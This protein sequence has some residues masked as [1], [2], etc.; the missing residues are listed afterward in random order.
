[1]N[2]AFPPLIFTFNKA[3]I[4]LLLLVAQRATSQT[5]TLEPFSSGFNWLV[6]IANAPGD[7]HLFAFQ[8]DGLI[9]IVNANGTPGGTFLD[10]G[11]KLINQDEYGL[12]GLV[13]HPGYAL[14]GFFYVYYNQVG[15]GRCIIARYNRSAANP[16]LA[17]PNSELILLSFDHP[18]SHHVGGCMKFGWDGKLYIATGDGA[19]LTAPSTAAQNLQSYLGKVLRIDVN[20]GN[21]YSVPTNN[22]FVNN[23]NAKPEIWAYGLRNPWR[24]S[25]DR[26]LGDLWIADVGQDQREEI[27][28]QP[29]NN[30]G[31]Q[32]YGWPCMEG[33]LQFNPTNCN[34][35]TTYTAPYYEYNHAT[36][37]G[38]SI[39]GGVVYRGTEY[40]DLFGKYIYSDFCSGRI[41]ALNN[42]GATPVIVEGA[43]VAD[44][45]ITM[46]EEN[47]KGELF[48]V[49]FFSN[50]IYRVRSQNCTPVAI[51]NGGAVQ[52]IPVGGSLDL[53]AYS[54]G[55]NYNYQWKLNGTNLPNQTGP[56][57]TVTQPGSYTLMVTK[58]GTNCTNTSAAVT[59]NGGGGTGGGNG[60]DLSL[61]LQQLTASPAQWSN[62]PVKLT[63]SNAGSQAATG[64]KVKFAK[65]TGVVYVGGNEFT[66]SQ[67]TFNP[68]GDEV[69]TVGSIP[70]NGSA[71]LTVNYFLLN[72]TAPV[73]Y[74]QVT[75]ANET[76]SDSQPNNGTPPTPVQDDE[77]STAGGS[78]G[79]NCQLSPTITPGFCLG[80]NTPD[81]SDDSYNITI[82]ATATGTTSTG[83]EVSTVFPNGFLWGT[84]GTYGVPQEVLAIPVSWG[85]RTYT[86]TDAG[87]PSC[88]ATVNVTPPPC[89]PQNVPNLNLTN[90]TTNI[91]AQPMPQ[92]AN[93][94]F[95][96][97]LFNGTSTPVSSAFTVKLY[98]SV[99]A[100]FDAGDLVIGT[101]SYP[102]FAANTL[103]QNQP[104]TATVPTNQPV[105]TYTLFVRADA[106]NVIT[107]LNEADNQDRILNG[108]AVVA[109]ST[110]GG[111]IDLSLTAQQLTASPAQWS[112]YPVKLTLSNTGPQ[113]ATGVK[114]KF[115]K[116]TGVVYVGGNEFTASQGT[117]NPNGDEVWTVG[118]IPANGSATLTVNYFLLN[119]TAPIAYAQ[120]TA[121]NET[122]A[123]SQPNNGTPPTPVQDDE[124]STAG[125]TP[126]PMPDLTLSN[127]SIP[128]TFILT[129][130]TAISYNVNNIGNAPSSS[131]QAFITRFYLSID[132]TLSANDLAVGEGI[133]GPVAAGGN[134]TGAGA[135]VTI[136]AS[137]AVGSYFLIGKTDADNTVAESNENNNLSNAVAVQV[138]SNNTLSV[139]LTASNLTAP[140]TGARGAAQ[141]AYS[142]KVNNIGTS[143]VS[144]PGGAGCQLFLSTDNVQG[145]AD[146][147]SLGI[148]GVSVGSTIQP[149]G[150]QLVAGTFTIQA[151]VQPGNYF[152]YAKADVF[153]EV[154]ENN[155]NNNNTQMA[156]LSVTNS[157]ITGTDLSPTSFSGGITVNGN[158]RYF[159]YT[160]VAQNTGTAI[161]GTSTVTVGF[162]LSTDNLLSSNDYLILST[163]LGNNGSGLFLSS[164][165][166]ITVPNSFPAGNYFVIAKVDDTAIYN[167]TN[168]NNNTNSIAVTVGGGPQ[169]DLTIADL[170]IPTTSVAAGAILSYNFDA[171]NAGTAGVPGNFTIKS[172]ISTDQTLSANDLQ[173]GTIQTGNY[174]VGF[175]VQNV[176]GASTIPANLA[177]GQYYLM[178]K[179][180]AD[181]F[182]VEGNENNNTVV[183]PFTVTSGG[184]LC[185]AV[186]ITPGPSKIT[187][188]GFSAPH[189][190]IKVFKPNWTVAY[191]CLDG[192]CAN[193]TVVTGLGTGNHFVE[194][195]LMNA[196]WGEICKKTQTVGVTS[197]VAEQDERM[198][199]SFDRIYP[200]PTAYLTTMELYSPVEQAATLDFYDQQGRQVHTMKV[201]LEKGTNR[202]EQMV[203]DW[204]SG[205]YNVIVRG[206]G[207]ALPA[208]GRFLKVWEE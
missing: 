86:F 56:A 101:V 163:S 73:A 183:L 125:G 35:N 137:T 61:T 205:T 168:E 52:S 67:G 66:A 51:I 198:R 200:N 75:A 48:A 84:A 69:W 127:G 195:K 156:D 104:G 207:T 166:L 115:A 24:I 4:V 113:A 190:L 42:S 68:N 123:D 96:Y 36:T 160:Y 184:S 182:V 148:V 76:D 114:V 8:K 64:V 107:E 18:E 95:A 93:F 141:L 149:G 135:V 33:T 71:T 32:N 172:Y 181:G 59:V 16:N 77:A 131:I 145:N 78:T 17:D 27:D 40:V 5:L 192:Q 44:N 38:C 150:N 97:N 108:I 155:E 34:A 201:V 19:S 119:A 28:F 3:L 79:S 187:I 185:A 197:L 37:N 117:F 13:F 72:A 53:V 111:Q 199:L 103:L 167:E 109:G 129:A 54:A 147:Q 81:P 177:A 12:V 6:G 171:S 169:P 62:Y 20:N 88:T 116:P 161:P 143:P 29:V 26:A 1:M 180:D 82:N 45:D 151:S 130:N 43:N 174:G 162:Y 178:V 47:S 170:Q 193:P 2:K 208:Y 204:R 124:A 165:D 39:S 21:P 128:S 105:G 102:N 121:A 191:E 91:G 55:V 10:I 188:A 139:D 142:F 99:D 153:N 41:W 136:P 132:N 112:N 23:P 196:S 126:T 120:V 176:P 14:N 154:V 9:K 194:V 134:I 74:A 140:T 158:T 118:S 60:I 49:G 179:I 87:N 206:E 50:N 146:D 175:A 157:T 7:D 31:G 144:F 106:D 70:A 46:I 110:G 202:I 90:L 98:L 63:L 164:N 57:I 85:T 11:S 100:A 122:D 189:V 89:V 22:P 133:A 186:T 203:S 83:Y 80:A 30:T 94:S 152:L 15:T 138:V 92:G 159:G 58:P 25:F 65:P 173:D